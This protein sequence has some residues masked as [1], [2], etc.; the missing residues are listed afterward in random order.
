MI[1]RNK[2]NT[3]KKMALGTTA[4]GAGMVT[5]G[6]AFAGLPGLR[7]S[8]SVDEP[9][10][11]SIEVT[12]RVSATK[13]DLEIVVSNAGQQPVNITQMTP[14]T[15]RVPRGEFDF[16]SLLKNGPL[17][18]EAGQAVTVPLK[19]MP[20]QVAASAQTLSDSLRKSMSVITDNNAYASV[21]I[22]GVTVV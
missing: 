5:G 4:L 14:R 21:T 10:L 15:L 17:R 12:T 7:E 22:P 1:D 9:E 19:R 3:L 13:N 2:R 11:G 20:V 16:S 18:L 8:L 6:A